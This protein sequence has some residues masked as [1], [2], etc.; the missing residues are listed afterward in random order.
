MHWQG[1]G[2]PLMPC[3]NKFKETSAKIVNKHP[4]RTACGLRKGKPPYPVG[5]SL[6][7]PVQ[8]L[9]ID[10]ETEG[11][12]TEG[13]DW[14]RLPFVLLFKCKIDDL[15][16]S[17]L[18]LVSPCPLSK[19][20]SSPPPLDTHGFRLLYRHGHVDCWYVD[21]TCWQEVPTGYENRG[22]PCTIL[23][24][25]FKDTTNGYGVLWV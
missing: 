6:R 19:P 7:R 15:C 13:N 25:A 9:S 21:K 23:D 5:I 12:C 10:I 8:R 2:R 14:P 11:S 17:L 3:R 20:R 18:I 1:V 4:N 24:Y 16:P 22:R